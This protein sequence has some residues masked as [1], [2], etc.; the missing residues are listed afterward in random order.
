MIDD[1][2]IKAGEVALAI[3]DGSKLKPDPDL[4]KWPFLLSTVVNPLFYTF[5]VK[6]RAFYA[7]DRCDSCRICEHICP[8]NCI[9][10]EANESGE[11]R[12]QWSDNCTHCMS[13][14][15]HCPTKAIEYGKASRNKRRYY[16]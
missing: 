2:E 13:C 8:L 6:S 12:P 1:G 7:D 14:I 3:K 11:L 15:N 10:M 16:I 5:L 9:S 4:C